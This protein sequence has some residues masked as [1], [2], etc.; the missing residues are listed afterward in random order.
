MNDRLNGISVFVQAVEAGSF[1]LAAERLHLTRSAVAKTIARIEER[2]GTRLF[3]RTTRMQTLTED[4]QIYYERCVRALAE[5]EAGEA[6]LNSGRREPAGL[7]RVSAPV[8]FGRYCVAPSMLRLSAA[9]PELNVDISFTDRV[10]DL[11]DEGYDLAVRV[12]TL[13]DSTTLV[14]R[15]IGVQGM[16]VCAAAAYLDKHGR[17]RTIDELRQHNCIVY[18]RNGSQFPWRLHEEDGRVRE[19]V[20]DTRLRFDDLQAIADAAIA[21]HGLAWLPCWLV[22]RYLHGGE[23]EP[24]LDC[25]R[26]TP[27]DIHAVWPQTPYL[28][29]KTRAAI[30]IL[31]AEAPK[32]MASKVERPAV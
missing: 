24:V 5:L 6:A 32:W 2:L 29:A 1:S 12:G 8:L 21:G 17:P 26:I 10:V 30:D 19:L 15:R 23:L 13:P 20:F 25:G 28:P 18:G 4:G 27:A 9:H 11:I 16:V 3:H 22:S 14:S 31:L 7:L